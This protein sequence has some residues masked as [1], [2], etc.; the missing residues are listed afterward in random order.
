MFNDTQFYEALRQVQSGE[1][2]PEA[3]A[4]FHW[5]PEL[6][7]DTRLAGDQVAQI[8]RIAKAA[9]ADDSVARALADLM[10]AHN[11]LKA[12]HLHFH[13][14]LETFRLSTDMEFPIAG[15]AGAHAARTAE[16]LPADLEVELHKTA[17]K[18]ARRA[19]FGELPTVAELRELPANDPQ[20]RDIANKGDLYRRFR[21]DYTE[22]KREFELAQAAGLI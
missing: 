22:Y 3:K 5:Q 17:A 14:Q 9:Y 2:K 21:S 19:V 6:Q 11:E 15:Q 8:R 1:I 10:E 13:Q 4:A 7:V 12:A 18:A 20:R 16:P